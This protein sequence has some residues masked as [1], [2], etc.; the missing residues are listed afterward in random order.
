MKIGLISDTHD[1]VVNTLKAVRIFNERAV[2]YV[3]HA[4]DIIA[5]FMYWPLQRLNMPWRAVIG[6]NRG[7]L[8]LWKG[9]VSENPD[10]L[11]MNQDIELGG[12]KFHI[13]HEEDKAIK[14]AEDGDYDYVIC[15]H[16]HTPLEKRIGKTRLINAGSASM[17]V[18]DKRCYDRAIISI[19]DTETDDLERISINNGEHLFDLH[20]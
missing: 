5:P 11:Q 12:K 3:L 9:L 4:G 1:N 6:N 14:A 7:D 16:T 18:E 2:D 13:V 15:G 10:C 17:T 20:F 8:D 19:L